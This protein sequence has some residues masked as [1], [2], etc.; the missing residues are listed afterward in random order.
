MC[1]ECIG[2]CSYILIGFERLKKLSAI[3]GI[4]YLIISS[5]PSSLFI[6]SNIYIY[7]NYGTFIKINIELLLESSTKNFFFFKLI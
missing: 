7:Q 5:I 6:L 2:F 1:L 3:C 4:Q